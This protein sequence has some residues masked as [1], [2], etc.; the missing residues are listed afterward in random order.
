MTVPCSLSLQTT[1]NINPTRFVR[2]F[3]VYP[4][5]HLLLF[6]FDIL[7]LLVSSMAATW[8]GRAPSFAPGR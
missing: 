3:Y 8:F 6:L 5:H 2:F 1:L 7:L 4:M